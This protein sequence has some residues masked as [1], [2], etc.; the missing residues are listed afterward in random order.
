MLVVDFLKER[1]QP[2]RC[3]VPG[4][5]FPMFFPAG[6]SRLQS[7]AV[8]SFI[9][10]IEVTLITIAEEGWNTVQ[11]ALCGRG[12]VKLYNVRKAW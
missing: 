7:S 3:D 1:V 10:K 12:N 4:P 8:K 6:G 11:E 5:I 2:Q 9:C